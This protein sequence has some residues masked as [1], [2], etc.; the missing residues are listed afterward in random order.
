MIRKE[1]MWN[2]RKGGD[3]GCYYAREEG[4]GKGLVLRVLKHLLCEITF[5]VCN[6]K[7][8][9]ERLLTSKK[10]LATWEIQMRYENSCA[11]M[12]WDA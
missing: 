8:C 9:K 6:V 1:D 11:K 7:E 12:R 10:L 4:H 5:P 2:I 3:E